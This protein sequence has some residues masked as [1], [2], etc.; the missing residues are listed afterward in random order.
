MK[1]NNENGK[2][3]VKVFWLT[4]LVISIVLTI[5]LNLVF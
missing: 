5:V 4:S 3:V 1:Y 2:V